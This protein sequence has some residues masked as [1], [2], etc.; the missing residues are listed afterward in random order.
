MPG[1]STNR[2]S[3]LDRAISGL[4]DQGLIATTASAD[5]L[6][7]SAGDGGQE[8]ILTNVQL[9]ELM[10]NDQLTWQGIK[11]LHREI[12]RNQLSAS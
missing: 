10:D 1:I 9:L 2:P 5:K 12:G 8:Y 11:D 6:N 4:R 3:R 7:V